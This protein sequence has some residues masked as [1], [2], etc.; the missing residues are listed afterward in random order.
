MLQGNMK[1]KEK[2]IH[3]TQKPVRLYEW[4]LK[5][6]AKE[7]DTI[8]DTH[9][10]SMSLVIACI[11]MGYEI[12]CFELDEEYYEAAAKRIIEHQKQTRLILT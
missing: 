9:G 12:T 1:N 7:G 6:Y 8:L 11:N 3:P 4:I 2:R 10:G 5:N